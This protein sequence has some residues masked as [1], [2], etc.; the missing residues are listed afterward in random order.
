MTANCALVLDSF[1]F[2]NALTCNVLENHG[3]EKTLS[4][5]DYAGAI[6]KVN[7]YQPS[8]VIM[9]VQGIEASAATITKSI[10]D[11]DKDISIILIGMELNDEILNALDLGAKAFL[12]KPFNEDKLVETVYKVAPVASR[13]V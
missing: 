6:K 3:Y 9:D 10:L 1:K 8:L 2:M 12:S 13:Q 4:S 7:E 11:I 5:L